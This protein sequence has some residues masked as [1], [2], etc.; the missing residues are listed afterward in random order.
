MVPIAYVR[1]MRAKAVFTSFINPVV[2]S[3]KT[4]LYETNKPEPSNITTAIN[5]SETRT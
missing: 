5:S 4:S 1:N 3:R 2:T